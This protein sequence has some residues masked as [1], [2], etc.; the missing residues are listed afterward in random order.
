M[1]RLL[2][3]L[4]LASSLALLAGRPRFGSGFV[5]AP[6]WAPTS[7]YGTLGYT[8]INAGG[9]SDAHIGAITGRI[10]ERFGKYFGV[11]G[12]LSGGR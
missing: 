3:P 12:E 8:G 7:T 5:S 4:G 11:E 10:G 9:G 1:H 2:L 6:W